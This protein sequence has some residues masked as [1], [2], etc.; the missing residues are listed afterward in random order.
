MRKL[1]SRDARRLMDRM[2]VKFEEISDA[3]QVI[4]KTSD[5]EIVIDDPDVTI[6][7]IKG[8]KM[9]Q[10]AG[11]VS[12]RTASEEG[13]SE[14][15]VETMRGIQD[16]DVQL[17]AQQ[18]KVSLEEAKKALEETGGDLAK[19]ILTLRQQKP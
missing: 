15:A 13:A 4:I 14:K 11:H 17:V 7:D 1:G 18:T 8:E 9:F 19:A 3:H 5:K 10:I 2:G 16:E 6:M 12:E